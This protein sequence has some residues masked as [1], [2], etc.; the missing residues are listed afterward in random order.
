MA[1]RPGPAEWQLDDAYPGH[2]FAANHPA[3]QALVQCYH[4]AGAAPQVWPWAIG[5]MPAYAFAP[6]APCL[7]IG[8]LGRGG[9]AHGVDEFVTLAGLQRFLSFL[10][11]WLPATAAAL[12]QAG[13]LS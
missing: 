9:N 8:G 3:V 12:T 10:L 1:A 6:V 7:L 4:D 13:D 11:A 5:A 2:R